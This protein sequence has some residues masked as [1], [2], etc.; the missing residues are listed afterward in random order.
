MIS[1]VMVNRRTVLKGG[2]MVGIGVVIAGLWLVSTVM[3]RPSCREWNTA[4]F[5]KTATPS[6]VSRCLET[7]DRNIE[8]H[9]ENGVTPL[10]WAAAKSDSPAV[11][12]IL[13]DSGANIE[14][15]A[16]DPVRA[17]LGANIEAAGKALALDKRKYEGT[18]L[19]WAAESSNSP[20]LVRALLDSGANIEAKD[21]DGGTPLHWAAESSSS[22][23]VVRALLDAGANIQ[24]QDNDGRIPLHRA[25]ESS[26]S[27]AVVN[28]LLDASGQP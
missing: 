14:A 13:L 26:N 7:M 16:P 22:P 17:I 18:P 28:T 10:H 27:S 4:A 2:L 21:N 6:D 5:F 25:A 23:D 12:R 3:Q 20:A 19:H 8:V 9:A 1:G 24:A 15:Q 11:V